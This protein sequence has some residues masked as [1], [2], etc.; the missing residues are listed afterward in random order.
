MNS[1]KPCRF[2]TAYSVYCLYA[3]LYHFCWTA[4]FITN[5]ITVRVVCR[6]DWLSDGHS[7]LPAVFHP[8]HYHWHQTPDVC[9]RACA[10][11]LSAS[12]WRA[13][14]EWFKNFESEIGR[15]GSLKD[16]RKKEMR[17][18]SQGQTRQLRELCRVCR[19]LVEYLGTAIPDIFWLFDE[20]L[21]EN[22]VRLHRR[23]YVEPSIN[24]SK[25]NSIWLYCLPRRLQGRCHAIDTVNMWIVE[26]FLMTCI[27]FNTFVI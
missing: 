8:Y 25:R 24:Q 2:N 20:S 11:C 22:Q 7:G 6:I 9:S 17:I 10:M 27:I 23:I 14:S 16:L 3:S 1:P 4:E 21:N 12:K 18:V 26:V 13:V 19:S 5:Q 15:R